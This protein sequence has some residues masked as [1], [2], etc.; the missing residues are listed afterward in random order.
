MLRTCRWHAPALALLLVQLCHIGGVAAQFSDS[1]GASGTP[2]SNGTARP[3]FVEPH[4]KLEPHHGTPLHRVFACSKRLLAM[5][6]KEEHTADAIRSDATCCMRT[7]LAGMAH[8]I[9][10]CAQ[11]QTPVAACH[12]SQPG[13]HPWKQAHGTWA[14]MAACMGHG[15]CMEV[16][17]PQQ[18]PKGMAIGMVKAA[19]YTS[20][21]PPSMDA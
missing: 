18:R 16:G 2:P 15:V 14:C 11:K 7:M 1:G 4:T 13:R 21:Q 20:Q 17:Q 19:P 10:A 6:S 3:R 9:N 12:D 5:A 8:A